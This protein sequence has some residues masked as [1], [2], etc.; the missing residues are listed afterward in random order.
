[1]LFLF[2][3]SCIDKRIY[4]EGHP[5]SATVGENC[6]SH[7]SPEKAT[8]SKNIKTD[9]DSTQGLPGNVKDKDGVAYRV[10]SHALNWMSRWWKKGGTPTKS[11]NVCSGKGLPLKFQSY[12]DGLF[13]R[14]SDADGAIVYGASKPS[15]AKPKGKKWHPSSVIP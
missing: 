1:M 9:D 15:M 3:E 7:K 12:S 10:I 6:R 4:S 2:T 14:E 8:N 11:Q 5:T 13:E